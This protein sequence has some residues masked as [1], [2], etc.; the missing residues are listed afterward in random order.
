M[1][2]QVAANV[3]TKTLLSSRTITRAADKTEQNLL[4]YQRRAL[5]SKARGPRFDT[6]IVT[7]DRCT[8]ECISKLDV[9]IRLVKVDRVTARDRLRQ[10]IEVVK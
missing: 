4:R 9:N 5:T 1:S 7:D 6:A 10:E 2:A 3:I 8:G